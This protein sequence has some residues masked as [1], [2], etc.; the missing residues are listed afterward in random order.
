MALLAFLAL[1]L[2]E[3]LGPA[4]PASVQRAF[5]D[6]VRAGRERLVIP[7]GTYRLPP[8][9]GL[10]SLT[11]RNAKDLQI[12]ATGAEFLISDLRK[13]GLQFFRCRN[14]RL[15][16]LS[17]RHETPPFTQG[18]IDAIADDELSYDVRLHD[19]YPADFDNASLFPV[20]PTG[21]VFDS[22]T[23]QWKAGT[24]DV[25]ADRV[26]RLGDRKFR[27]HFPRKSGASLHA[28]AVGDLIAFRGR[29]F[30]DIHLGSCAGMRIENVTIRHGG[31]FCVHEEGGD[32][33][34]FYRYAVTYGPTPTG[35]TEAPLMACNADAFH[36]SGVRKGPTLDGCSFEGMGDDGI[37]IHGAY[38][39]VVESREKSWV[40]TDGVLR[41]GDP[42]RLFDPDGAPAGESKVT[43]IRRLPDYAPSGRSRFKGFEDLPSRRFVEIVADPSL[44]AG[45]DWQASNP[46][47]LGSG[48]VVRNNVIRNHRARGILIKA[49]D[50]LIEGNTIDG[51]TIAGIVLAPE[52][53]W[54]EA[55]YSRNVTIRNNTIRRCGTATSG[56]WT[57][58]A[59]ALSVT[60]ESKPGA[61]PGHRRIAIEN[62]RFLE[63][64]GVNL[65]LRAVDGAVVTG[66]RFERPGQAVAR[67]GAGHKIDFSALIWVSDCR[68]VRFDGN[69]VASPGNG[70]KT[71]LGVG[72]NVVDLAGAAT[73]IVREK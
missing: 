36:S 58:Q 71:W 47:A 37:P 48:F 73:G 27:L 55:C 66:N 72:P 39:L 10:W 17:I 50:G 69:V 32:G 42:V 34:N 49:D 11:I 61:K 65:L 22:R 56:P 18:R 7:P 43:S 52:L 59:G 31:G 38:A 23:R 16:G 1:A 12:E 30:T 70:C 54:R 62:N 63:N 64:D 6:A 41:E 46:A 5:D 68:N 19:G 40:T 2:Q 60:A 14:V 24:I 8:T 29:G 51:S 44:P 3:P 53:F 21:Y 25:T 9:D 26:E 57:S 28:A 13:G 45:F 35:A 33:G 15:T 67:R 4:D 20:R